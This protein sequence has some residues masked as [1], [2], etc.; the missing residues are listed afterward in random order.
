MRQEHAVE[1]ARGNL[2]KGDPVARRRLAAVAGVRQQA[3]CNGNCPTAAPS[4]VTST[5]GP[6]ASPT[7]P[8]WLCRAKAMMP[9][10]GG[11]AG[12]WCRDDP[13]VAAD[14]PTTD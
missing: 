4:G 13:G 14:V 7:V 1:R 12:A 8:A 9:V 10:A 5:T 6:T 11:V 3:C 2:V